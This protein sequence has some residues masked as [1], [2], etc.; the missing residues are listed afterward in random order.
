M[1]LL[2]KSLKETTVGDARRRRAAWKVS[3]I[4]MATTFFVIS[5]TGREIMWD[6]RTGNLRFYSAGSGD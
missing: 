4:E 3:I 2:A 1:A 5:T 6:A